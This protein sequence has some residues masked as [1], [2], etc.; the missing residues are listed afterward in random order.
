MQIYFLIY[1]MK[2]I[3]DTLG[4]FERNLNYAILTRLIPKLRDAAELK[5]P[6]NKLFFH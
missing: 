1:N 5:K 2:R 6:G 3:Y 4:Q